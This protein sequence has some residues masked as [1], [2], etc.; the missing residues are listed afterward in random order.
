MLGTN[1]K[2]CYREGR[3]VLTR[4]V[5]A[6]SAERIVKIARGFEYTA[7]LTHDG[8]VLTSALMT[9][10]YVYIWGELGETFE[11]CMAPQLIQDL[12]LKNVVDI[13]SQNHQCGVL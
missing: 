2:L 10:G 4:V 12:R 7:A 13:F 9:N 11:S 6:L 1:G 5:E 3:F 8:K